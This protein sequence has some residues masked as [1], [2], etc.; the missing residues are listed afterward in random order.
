MATRRGGGKRFMWCPDCRHKTVY[1]T[2]RDGAFQYRCRRANCGFFCYGFHGD[3]RH[4]EARERL[5][6]SNKE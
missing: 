1:Q 2:Y 5:A 6:E 4:E 3:A